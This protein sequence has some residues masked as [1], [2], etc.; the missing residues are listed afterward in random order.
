MYLSHF[1]SEMHYVTYRY[2]Y[3]TFMLIF[4]AFLGFLKI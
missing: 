1:L 3:V 4:K 2:F